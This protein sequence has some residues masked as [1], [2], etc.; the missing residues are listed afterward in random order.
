MKKIKP[1][2]FQFI[3]PAII[4]VIV[5][6]LALSPLQLQSAGT[7]FFAW[8]AFSWHDILVLDFYVISQLWNCMCVCAFFMH[9]FSGTSS[10]SPLVYYA[11]VHYSELWTENHYPDISVSLLCIQF[12]FFCSIPF[13]N[14]ADEF[15]TVFCYLYKRERKRQQRKK[16]TDFF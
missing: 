11:T 9:A 3:I 14:N 6:C 16:S 8:K 2:A 12:Q 13:L 4:F 10:Q 15:N 1:N 5:F 7:M